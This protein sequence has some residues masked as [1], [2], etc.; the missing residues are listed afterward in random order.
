MDE[1]VKNLNLEIFSLL[2][3]KNP[4]TSSKHCLCII[5]VYTEALIPVQF[6][7]VMRGNYQEKKSSVVAVGEKRVQYKISS[8]TCSTAVYLTYTKH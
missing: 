5:Y 3:K 7:F 8:S 2:W 1:T 6:L 4:I